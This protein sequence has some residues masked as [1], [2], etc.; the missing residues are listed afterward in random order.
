MSLE[1][2]VARLRAE[3]VAVH[4]AVCECASCVRGFRSLSYDRTITSNQ[5]RTA[6][7]AGQVPHVGAPTIPAV[8]FPIA[9]NIYDRTHFHWHRR[10]YL[11]TAKKS[12]LYRVT[13]HSMDVR[14]HNGAGKMD[15]VIAA[16]IHRG[17]RK[18]MKA[19]VLFPLGHGNQLVLRGGWPYSFTIDV[20]VPDGQSTRPETFEWRHSKSVAVKRLG[21]HSGYKL[22]R[23]STDVGNGGGGVATG[24]GEVV[25]VLAFPHGLAWSKA[26]LFM[27]RKWNLLPCLKQFPEW[28]FGGT[29]KSNNIRHQ[30]TRLTCTRGE[31]CAGTPGRALAARYCDD[32]HGHLGL[33]TQKSSTYIYIVR[34]WDRENILEINDVKIPGTLRNRS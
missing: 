6:R 11:G 13:P 14:L 19:H 21:H 29:L 25:A 9:F 3:P 26:G 23:L 28:H 16:F 10:V 31:W 1:A 12:S 27:F 4:P 20:P 34:R 18:S 22:V 30:N 33:Q 8:G 17:P 32:C 7:N 15:P 2:D 24:G 5:P